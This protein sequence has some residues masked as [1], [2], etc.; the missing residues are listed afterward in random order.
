MVILKRFSVEVVVL[1][2]FEVSVGVFLLSGE[3]D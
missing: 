1:R 3:R 2:W